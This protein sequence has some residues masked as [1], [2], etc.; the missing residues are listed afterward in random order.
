[1]YLLEDAQPRRFRSDTA[2]D[3]QLVRRVIR[4][5]PVS[6]GTYWDNQRGKVKRVYRDVPPRVTE[7][8]AASLKDAFGAPGLMLAEKERK[9]SQRAAEEKQKLASALRE[10]E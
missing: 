4:L 1:M 2:F 5:A 9:D 10:L 7:A 3:Y 6:A 8:L